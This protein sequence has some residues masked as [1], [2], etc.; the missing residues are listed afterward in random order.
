MLE[1]LD[2]FF[3]IFHTLLILVNLFGWAWRRTRRL[4]FITLC[5]TGCSWFILGI[6]YGWGYCPFTD[7]HFTVLYKLGENNLPNSYIKHLI[8]RLF[9]C[10][11]NARLVDGATL[12]LF[13]VALIFSVY[14][15]FI[16]KKK[17]CQGQRP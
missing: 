2:I 11:I 12:G 1:F 8:D 17:P 10:D 14:F 3:V 4:N 15:N 16:R 13:F 9:H 5:L 7:W 6:F